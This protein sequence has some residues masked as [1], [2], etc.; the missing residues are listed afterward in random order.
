MLHVGCFGQS[1]YI[2]TYPSL[3]AIVCSSAFITL[4]IYLKTSTSDVLVPYIVE[5]FMV[6]AAPQLYLLQY[7]PFHD[8][9]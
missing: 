8:T 1:T 7:F 6:L 4:N 5:A 9:S 3:E 2:Q